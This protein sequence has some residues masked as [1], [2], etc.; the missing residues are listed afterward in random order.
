MTRFEID[1][2]GFKTQM[3]EMPLWRLIQ[4]IIS[5]SFDESSVKNIDCLIE[6][7]QTGNR[8]I[9]ITVSDDGDGFRDVK[10]VYTLYKDSYKRTNSKQR[11]RFNLGDKQFF[12]VALQGAVYTG[13][14]IVTFYDDK[15]DVKSA[16]NVIKGVKVTGIFESQESIDDIIRELKKVI[17]PSDKT[18]TINSEIINH[19]EPIR[20]FK[21]ILRTPIAVGA[22]QKLVQVKQETEV[23]LYE[24]IKEEKPLLM[25]LGVPVQELQENINWHIDVRQKV[26]ITTSRDVVT[27]LYLQTLYAEIAKNTLDLIDN[28]SSGAN[29]IND[30]LKQSDEKTSRE[31][32]TKQYG[33]DK[34]M[35]ESSV[36]PRANEKALEAGYILIKGNTLDADVRENLIKTNDII[37]YA[38]K[39]FETTFA[40]AKHVEPNEKMKE[41]AF[42]VESVSR[43]VTGRNIFCRFFSMPNGSDTANYCNNVISWNVGHLGKKFF[44]NF[45]EKAVGILIHELA[46]AIDKSDCGQYSHLKMEYI[47]SFEKVAGKIGMKGINY[48]I[49]RIEVINQ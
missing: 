5:N 22:N 28:V 35:I 23:M 26:P 14:N 37:N 27:D 38:G 17:V 13:N 15:R 34:V 42:I 11:G 32:L 47:K 8:E 33:T 43:D 31:I 1:T 9:L 44:D 29:W 16:N 24:K 7:S 10:D 41:F 36:D 18:Y 2:D 49:S 48:W 46:H 45:S 6:N 12:A 3:S 20:I 40:D 39:V 25:E 19:V 21:S 4:E 30:A